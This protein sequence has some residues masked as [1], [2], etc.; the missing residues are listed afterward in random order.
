[1]AHVM[2]ELIGTLV[3]EG[4]PPSHAHACPG[5]PVGFAPSAQAARK[6]VALLHINKRDLSHIPV[7]D[8]HAP[9]CLGFDGDSGE[10][11]KKNG[12]DRIVGKDFTF[13]LT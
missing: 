11:E 6:R 4:T 1:M 2:A 12:I 13:S 9:Y 10:W 3:S 8:C 5:C 7:H